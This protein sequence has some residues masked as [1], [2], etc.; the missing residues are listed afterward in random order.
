MTPSPKFNNQQNIGLRMSF[1]LLGL[2]MSFQ[3]LS[4]RG[5]GRPFLEFFYIFLV[6]MRQQSIIFIGWNYTKQ[7]KTRRA[8]LHGT[9]RAPLRGTRAA[10]A[11]IDWRQLQDV[12]R[13]M[14]STIPRRL[15]RTRESTHPKTKNTRTST[16][17]NI[18]FCKWDNNWKRELDYFKMILY[19]L[20]R[21]PS[22]STRSSLFHHK[23]SVEARKHIPGS[24]YFEFC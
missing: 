7:V 9:V 21:P 17:E 16:W 19:L 8:A 6:I 22:L 13:L 1:Q 3:L 11:R 12:G 2:R 4:A 24:S 20:H 10:A 5:D 14:R 15:S 18:N 23:E